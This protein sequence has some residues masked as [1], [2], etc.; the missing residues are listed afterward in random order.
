MYKILYPKDTL[1]KLLEP[2]PSDLVSDVRK[3]GGAGRKPAL[4][5]LYVY[6]ITQK[7]SMGMS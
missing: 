4:V 2:V 6:G 7:I 3:T 5:G 1:G